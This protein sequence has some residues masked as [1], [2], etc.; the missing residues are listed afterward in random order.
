MM[1]ASAAALVLAAAASAAAP[2]PGH[3]TPDE[4]S[5]LLG[6]PDPVALPYRGRVLEH[7]PSN[8]YLYLRVET[9]GR[10][11][12]L[13]A[14]RTA[15]PDHGRIRFGPGVLMRNFHSRRLDRTFPEILFV[16]RVAPDP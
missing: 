10:E 5:G 9:A 15:L 12:W 1:R 8:R 11:L 13:A 6:I 3:P 2:P 14:P 16:R 4:A 7:I